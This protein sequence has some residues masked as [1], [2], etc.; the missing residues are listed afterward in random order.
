MCHVPKELPF[1]W[2]R[3]ENPFKKAKLRHFW[4]ESV[5]LKSPFP[6]KWHIIGVCLKTNLTVS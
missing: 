5:V 1:F 2:K 4:W 3:V 6:K